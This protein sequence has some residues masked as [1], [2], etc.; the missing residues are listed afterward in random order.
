M[1]S[2]RDPKTNL[3]KP[4]YDLW[5]ERYGIHT[6]T[7]AAV[8]GALICAADFATM[9][10]K[11]DSASL[12]AQAAQDLQSAVMQHL[13]SEE[14]GYFYKSLTIHEDGTLEYN[15]TVD[16]SSS[17]GVFKFGLLEKDDERLEKAMILS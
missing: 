13:Y 17:Y 15:K 3:V 14:E 6:Y 8:Y 9:L 16:N 2:Y 7:C 10:G 5:E 4:S 12:Y 11:A 1:V